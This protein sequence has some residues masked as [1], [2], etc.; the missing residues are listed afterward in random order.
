[1][2]SADSTI[3]VSDYLNSGNTH[4]FNFVSSSGSSSSSSGIDFCE[5]ESKPQRID[6]AP[7]KSLNLNFQSGSQSSFNDRKPSLLI[8]L[9]PVNKL[10]CS[11]FF[12]STQPSAVVS[13]QRPSNTEERRHYRGVRQRPWG[14]FASEIRDPNRRGSRVW[15]GTFDTAIEAAKTYDRAAYK[16]RGRKAI[17][18]FPLEAGKSYKTNSAIDGGQKRRRDVGEDIERKPVKKE[19]SPQSDTS[20]NG[21][22]ARSFTSSSGTA[23]WGDQ[24]ANGIFSISPLSPLSPHSPLDY[25]QV[26]GSAS[27]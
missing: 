15:L 18:N 24:N 23:F 6:L 27:P 9:I 17:L 21:Q 10:E 20:T 5:F 1:M 2:S 13:I 16:M 25:P 22:M 12:E 4:V 26:H 8:N 19:R 14:K 7:P 11:E 3:T